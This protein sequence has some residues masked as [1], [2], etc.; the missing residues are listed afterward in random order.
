MD[1]LVCHKL[2]AL[3]KI[4]TVGFSQML[5]CGPVLNFIEKVV[6]SR[7]EGASEGLSLVRGKPGG[8]GS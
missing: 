3:S 5:F 7:P 4:S 2:A 1:C 8:N 6:I